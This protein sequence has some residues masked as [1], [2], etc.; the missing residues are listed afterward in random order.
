VCA[1][2]YNSGPKGFPGD[3]DNGE[4]S[5][6]YLL[7]ALGF[8]PLTPGRPEYVLT[9]PVFTKATIH[10]ANGREFVVAAPGNRDATVYVQKRI[11]NG[12][13]YSKTW[14]AHEAI[15]KGGQLHVEL[16]EKPKVRPIRADELPYSMSTDAG[17]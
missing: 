12:Q 7:N 17:N 14:I 11:L 13:S 1:E 4:M 2:L 15:V 9:S 6:W 3:E 10:L 16:A 8:Y 5:S